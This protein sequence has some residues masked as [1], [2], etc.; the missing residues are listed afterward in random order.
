[1]SAEG[2][3]AMDSRSPKRSA[4]APRVSWQVY[5]KAERGAESR[6]RTGGELPLMGKRSSNM[7]I[8]QNPPSAQTN[9]RGSERVRPLKSHVVNMETLHL[10]SGRANA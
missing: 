9:M 3:V 8:E 10:D 1:M 6:P 5:S 7:Y 2:Q 4:M